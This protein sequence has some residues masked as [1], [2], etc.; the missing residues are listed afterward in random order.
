MQCK[1]LTRKGVDYG[2]S[3]VA[4]AGVARKHGVNGG[5]GVIDKKRENVHATPSPKIIFLIESKLGWNH[6]QT[7]VYVADVDDFLL[8]NKI[9]KK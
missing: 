4:R 7:P 6:S 8:K 1:P 5:G 2:G 9:C 3:N